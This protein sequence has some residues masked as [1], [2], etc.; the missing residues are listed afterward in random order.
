M[1]KLRNRK[2]GKGTRRKKESS[3]KVREKKSKRKKKD[4]IRVDRKKNRGEK[5][6]IKKENPYLRKQKKKGKL[7]KLLK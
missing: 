7:L 4:G 5:N 2:H 1:K 3:K 6:L